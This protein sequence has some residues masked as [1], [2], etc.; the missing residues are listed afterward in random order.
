[1]TLPADRVL[2]LQLL[3]AN[4]GLKGQIAIMPASKYDLREEVY[5]NDV[6]VHE[7]GALCQHLTLQRRAGSLVARHELDRNW[8][9]AL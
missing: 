4:H 1:M 8:R 2:T 5:L 3:H 7:A 6:W 9:A